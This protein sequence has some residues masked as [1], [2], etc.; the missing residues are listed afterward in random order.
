MKAVCFILVFRVLRCLCQ[1]LSALTTSPFK[2]GRLLDWDDGCIYV[3]V[4]VELRWLSSYRFGAAPVSPA[5][6]P[7]VIGHRC[8]GCL[9]I[10][11][12]CIFSSCT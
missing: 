3:A 10:L 11:M 8:G 9:D 12:V 7:N 4:T 2:A 6:N 5:K 1:A